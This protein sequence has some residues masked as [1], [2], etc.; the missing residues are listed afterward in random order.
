MCVCIQTYTCTC[1]HCLYLLIYSF[2]HSF[3]DLFICLL[4]HTYIHTYIQTYRHRQRSGF[5]FRFYLHDHARVT[6]ERT[7]GHSKNRPLTQQLPYNTHPFEQT[8]PQDTACIENCAH[9]LRNAA[10]V[11]VIC[12]V[13]HVL[14]C[15]SRPHYPTLLTTIAQLA[16]CWAAHV[17]SLSSAIFPF[18]GQL[19]DS[20]R[21]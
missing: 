6:T 3:I 15:L 21:Q 18:Q 12:L 13:S 8:K 9:P 4:S 19:T 1:R 5:S 10:A 7:T 2:I 14:L 17:R 16:G 20:M 11:S